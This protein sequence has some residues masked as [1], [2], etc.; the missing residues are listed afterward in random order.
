MTDNQYTTNE[1]IVFPNGESISIKKELVSFK[2]WQ[3]TVLFDTYGNKPVIDFNN[4]PV[5][6]ELAIL[7]KF[8]SK[9]WNGV[10]V[11][12]YR[13][14]FRVGLPGL[15]DSVPLPEKQKIFFDTIYS[16]TKR[17]G[18]CWD[19]FL[20]KGNKLFFVELKRKK[21]DTI[22][23]SQIVWLQESLQSGLKPE[24]FLIVEWD[25]L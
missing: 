4:E 17:K 13:K 6:A 25:F 7:K 21:K 1:I 18:G 16:K 2:P 19:V 9:G 14:K 22:R 12:S 15:V 20:W 23:S 8:Q 5:F 3:G 10:W 11:D 24:N